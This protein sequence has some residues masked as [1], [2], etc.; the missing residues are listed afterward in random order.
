MIKMMEQKLEDLR[1]VYLAIPILCLNCGKPL[2]LGLKYSS[3]RRFCSK[4]CKKRFWNRK[5]YFKAHPDRKS[6]KSVERPRNKVIEALKVTLRQKRLENDQ[7]LIDLAN[8]QE[9]EPIYVLKPYCEV[10]GQKNGDLDFQT[11]KKGKLKVV[12]LQNHHI[13]YSPLEEVTLCLKCHMRLHNHFLKGK[14]VK[15]RQ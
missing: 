8:R 4:L 9:S 15:M 7:K 1:P 12:R 11:R 2:D 10:C 13:R 14:K 6:Y 5:Q 3:N